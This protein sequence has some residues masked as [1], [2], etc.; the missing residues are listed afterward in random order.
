MAVARPIKL[1]PRPT[2]LARVVSRKNLPTL[3]LAAVVLVLVGLIGRDVFFSPSA[4]TAAGL[5][6]ATVAMGTVT[7]SVTATGTLVPAQQ[8]NLG[9]K[10]SGTLTAVDVHV[11]DHVKSGQLLATIDSTPLQLALQQ[12]QATL[13]SAQATLDNTLSGTSL[14][15]AQH[16][17]DQANQNYSDAVNAANQTN[18]ADQSQLATDQ[19]TL[20]SDTATLNNDK[21]A[22]WYT[23]NG[24]AL[25]AYQNQLN[26]DQG[27]WQ[28]DLCNFSTTVPLPAICTADGLAIQADQNNIACTQGT[29]VA[30]CTF[31]QQ[32]MA[33]A[34][35]AASSPKFRVGRPGVS[36]VV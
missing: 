1:P 26:I 27:K 31:E 29:L 12:A 36:E 6:L 2:G 7:N 14:T 28:T 8:V 24:A 10:T 17:L 18:A 21:V 32:Q 22:Y 5:R 19:A 11:G 9:F 4:T 35:K 15:Q 30:G 20:N 34:F 3:A 25:Q 13:A 33:A 23:Q 16:S